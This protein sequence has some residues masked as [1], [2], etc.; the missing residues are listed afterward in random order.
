[1]AMAT[2]ATY[3]SVGSTPTCPSPD[4]NY[5][6]VGDAW[7][8]LE[9]TDMKDHP[10]ATADCEAVGARLAMFKTAQEY[11]AVKSFRGK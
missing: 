8:R 6:A 3:A 10:E 9:D 11:N 1:M 5:Q 4:L 2:A 7:Y